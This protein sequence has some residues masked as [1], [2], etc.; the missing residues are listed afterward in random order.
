MS[1]KTFNKFEKAANLVKLTNAERD[2]I[3]PFM[4]AG[5]DLYKIG[6]FNFRY[7]TKIGIPVN[8]T[9]TAKDEIPRGD[10]TVK[11]YEQVKWGSE[12]GKLLEEALVLTEKEQIFGIAREM[13][14]AKNQNILVTSL[15]G[16]G[17]ILMYYVMSSEI[18]HKFKLF[19][20]PLGLRMLYYTVLGLFMSGVYCFVTDFT[21]VSQEEAVDDELVK[22]GKEYVEAGVGFYDKLLKKNKAF[23]LLGGTNQ[24]TATG[25]INNYFRI[26]NIPLTDRKKFFA[27]TLK[28][29]DIDEAV[30]RT[31]EKLKKE[32][33]PKVKVEEPIVKVE[34][35]A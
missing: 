15:Y 25:N 12:G 27:D 8:Y 34:N 2:L 29:M 16:S 20:R 28:K 32:E 33:K 4:V 35:A 3:E 5:L 10:I 30:V 6:S 13:I 22:L 11:G 7:G 21:R 1:D 14:D 17:S 9:F 31:E 26:T 18:N 24:Y 23:Y 19:T